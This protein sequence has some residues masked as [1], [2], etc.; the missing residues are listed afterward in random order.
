MAI[1][2]S[3]S[4][5]FLVPP[6]RQNRGHIL[7]PFKSSFR[8]VHHQV[9]KHS[10]PPGNPSK[11]LSVPRVSSNSMYPIKRICTRKSTSLAW[12]SSLPDFDFLY[13]LSCG[14]LHPPPPSP[15]DLYPPRHS[16]PQVIDRVCAPERNNLNWK[17]TRDRRTT[18][19]NLPASLSAKNAIQRQEKTSPSQA[20]ASV[21]GNNQYAKCRLGGS[22]FKIYKPRGSRVLNLLRLQSTYNSCLLS[23]FFCYGAKFIRK[24]IFVWNL[25]SARHRRLEKS[26]PVG[27]CERVKSAPCIR[28][29]KLS[30]SAG[31]AGAGRARVTAEP[32]HGHKETTLMTEKPEDVPVTRLN[33]ETALPAQ[34]QDRGRS[35]ARVW[36]WI[37]WQSLPKNI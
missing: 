6:V 13:L 8:V 19:S 14:S 5:R 25:Q 9:S 4:Y 7:S 37:A 31:G 16:T 15:S 11:S 27:S 32:C 22:W 3:P 12:Q 30:C 28:C 23:F 1:L 29:C 34:W 20:A 36:H 18:T 10:S 21:P 26:L 24:F 33:P 17:R 35:R 2:D